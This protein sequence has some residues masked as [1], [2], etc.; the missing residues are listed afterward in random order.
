MSR[1]NR[2][3][4]QSAQLALKPLRQNS[5]SLSTLWAHSHFSQTSCLVCYCNQNPALSSIYS[6]EVFIIIRLVPICYGSQVKFFSKESPVLQSF[7]TVRPK[8]VVFPACSITVK[9]WVLFSLH[10]NK[11]F[12]FCWVT[13]TEGH[14]TFLY[15]RR[16]FE[17]GMF[18]SSFPDENSFFY[19]TKQMASNYIHNHLHLPFESVIHERLLQSPWRFLNIQNRTMDSGSIFTRTREWRTRQSV[20]KAPCTHEW[21]VITPMARMEQKRSGFPG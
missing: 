18:P 7:G 4:Y 12:D 2:I 16:S 1:G 19:D 11:H 13:R 10:K 14:K 3:I 6:S 9:H 15:R 8:A 5:W 21:A 17:V 20:W